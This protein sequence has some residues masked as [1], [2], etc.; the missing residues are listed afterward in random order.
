MPQHEAHTELNAQVVAVVAISGVGL[1]VL[2][3]L[4]AMLHADNR[5]TRVLHV[6]LPLP[7]VGLWRW[8]INIYIAF[9]GFINRPVFYI[10]HDVSGVGFCACLQ[11]VPT[12]LG[13]LE[14]HIVTS[15]S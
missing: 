2:P 4:A 6:F 14:R 11:V 13:V 9:V 5:L 1:L 8:Y 15:L 12:Q 7:P 3:Q 10:K